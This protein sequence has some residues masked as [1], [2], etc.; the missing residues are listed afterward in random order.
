MALLMA[1]PWPGNIRELQNVIEQSAVM[2]EEDEIGE[3]ALPAYLHA[4]AAVVAVPTTQQP[5][6]TLDSLSIPAAVEQTERT[7]IEQALRETGGNRTHAAELLEISLRSLL[8]KIARYEIDIPGQ[9]G[10]PPQ[11]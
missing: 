2:S 1:W 6:L 3:D 8:Q 9:V 11:R 5:G 10:R 7:L 4:E